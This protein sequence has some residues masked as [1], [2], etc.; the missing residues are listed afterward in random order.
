MNIAFKAG[1]RVINLA[2][3]R[4]GT[5]TGPGKLG[6]VNGSSKVATFLAPTGIIMLN[7]KTLLVA[8]TPSDLIRAVSLK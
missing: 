4:V 2:T 8:D 6:I 3:H 7:S 1:V 5:L